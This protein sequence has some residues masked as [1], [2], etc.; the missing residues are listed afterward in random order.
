MSPAGASHKPLRA[1]SCPVR[2]SSLGAAALLLAVVAGSGCLGSGPGSIFGGPQG[3]KDYLSDKTYTNWVIELDAIQGQVPNKSVL[4]ALHA[5]LGAAANKPGGIEITQDE[6]SL[7]SRGG[8]W[9]DKDVSDYE[10]AHHSRKT[11]G[12]TVVTHLMFL[13]GSST[14]DSGDQ[15]ILGIAYG[16]ETI[17][18]FSQTIRDSCSVLSGCLTSSD[19]ILQVVLVHEFGH[20]MGLVDNGIDMASPH[21]D[22]A[23]PGHSNDCNSV[24]YWAVETTAIL[25]F[26]CFGQTRPPTD[27]DAADRADVCKAG[28]KC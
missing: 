24:M 11:S 18:L 3:P 9:S 20:A 22:A 27:Y 2:T 28:G 12:S 14:R 17:V 23:H 26:N 16:H 13:D 15:K 5:R 19:Y 1:E 7:P 8:A 6:T 4:D 21:E 10:S 25:N